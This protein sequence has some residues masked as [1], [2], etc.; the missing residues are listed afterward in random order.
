MSELSDQMLIQSV[1]A[2]KSHNAFASLVK[3]Y[4]SGLRY[5]LRQITGGDEMLA[6]DIAQET[7]IKAFKSITM[8]NGQSKFSSWLYR[9][10]YNLFIS[11][12]R[13]ARNRELPYGD[14]QPE[15]RVTTSE[16][17]D[18]QRDLARAM[19]KLPPQ[20]RMALHLHLHKQL[21][22]QEI[23]TIMELP[24]GTAKTAINRGKKR[25]QEELSIWKLG[26]IS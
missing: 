6:D 14:D 25:L 3:R 24:L 15:H 13:V 8:F 11:H 9:I 23:C 12:H 5:S 18:L 26:A 7:F 1:V 21:T 22:H 4:Q 10:A 17:T 19:L 2:S 20:Q 16:E